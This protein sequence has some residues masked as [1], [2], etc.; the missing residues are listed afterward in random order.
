MESI[1]Q[2]CKRAEHIRSSSKKLLAFT[3]MTLVA[4][5]IVP[6]VKAQTFAEWF[7]QKNTQKK[8]LLQQIAALQVYASYYKTGNKIA[9]QGLGAITGS[10]FS[11]NG[12]HVTY[13]NNL[14]KASPEVKN[15]KQVSDILQWQKDII[16]RMSGLDKT[17]NL[18]ANEQQY[19]GQVKATLYQDCAAQMT[20]LQ[21]VI[22]DG[23]LQM[24]DKE[25]IAHLDQIH[26]D[27]QSNYFFASSFAAQVKAYANQR[28]RSG[29]NLTAEK[30]VY[31][32]Q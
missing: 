23:K 8:Y 3:M 13:Y 1:D 9:H 27:M 14:K 26:K 2:L 32:I 10:L 24:S 28:V 25:R 4:S 16:T 17:G 30:K 29:Q 19:I 20:E 31:G 18:T 15:N 12:L 6:T 11:E 22:S 21:N 5:A 7:D